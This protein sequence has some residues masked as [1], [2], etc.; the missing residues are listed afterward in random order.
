M[1]KEMTFPTLHLNGTSA[2]D[3][4]EGFERAYAALHDAQAA[5]AQTAPNGRDF[6]VQQ[7]GSYEK[8]LIE[9]SRRMKQ[10]RDVSDEVEALSQHVADEDMRRR[11]RRGH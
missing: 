1:E 10:L 3:L 4:L 2:K 5:L 7:P 9:H 11:E 6:Y 8:A